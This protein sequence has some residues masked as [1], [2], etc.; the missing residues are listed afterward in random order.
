M[1][2]EDLQFLFISYGVGWGERE[3]KPETRVG[4]FLGILQFV[5]CFSMLFSFL[6]EYLP[7]VLW[8]KEYLAFLGSWKVILPESIAVVVILLFC[9]YIPR[10]W[11]GLL[12]STIMVG[13]FQLAL[14]LSIEGAARY[15]QAY[16]ATYNGGGALIYAAE[17]TYIALFLT[18]LVFFLLVTAT[19][20]KAIK[21]SKT[22]KQESIALKED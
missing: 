13:L 16:N 14:I 22:A 7:D 21:N 2:Q 19:L 9:L 5:I 3:S 18:L 1:R 12:G 11:I 4:K 6:G 15:Q 10:T 20:T 17:G 8:R